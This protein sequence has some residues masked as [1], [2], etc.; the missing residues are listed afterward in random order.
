MTVSHHEPASSA[1]AISEQEV[2]EASRA[3]YC[4][5]SNGD[6]ALPRAGTSEKPTILKSKVGEAAGARQCRGQTE[7]AILYGRELKERD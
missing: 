1:T 3:M 5:R 2:G 4:R 7:A 6:T